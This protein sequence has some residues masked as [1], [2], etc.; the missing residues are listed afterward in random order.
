MSTPKGATP[1]PFARLCP[2]LIT[3]GGA[4]VFFFLTL[5]LSP[6]ITLANHDFA[7]D[8]HEVPKA[9][10]WQPG[11]K[12]LVIGGIHGDEPGGY[13]AAD[14]ALEGV[15]GKG[16]IH[17]IPRMN[18]RAII[19]NRRGVYAD[20]NRLFEHDISPR[21]PEQRT[22]RELISIIPQYD[23]ILSLHDG[24]GFYH[25]EYIDNVRNPRR[26]G[27]SIIIDTDIYHET[28]HGTVCLQCIAEEIIQTLNG[29]ILHEDHQF[30]VN[31]HNTASPQTIH[32]EQRTSL[33]F[34]TLTQLGV[35][36]FC[37]EASKLL[38]DI[39]QK[40]FYHINAIEGFAA[41]V[42]IEYHRPWNTY[43]DIGIF[44]AHTDHLHSVTI[45]INGA[46]RT[47]PP[48]GRIH[49]RP[50]DSIAV[51]EI[52]ASSPIGWYPDIYGTGFYDDSLRSFSVAEETK[53]VIRR[54]NEDRG[55]I[56][57]RL[58]DEPTEFFEALVDGE[59]HLLRQ[60]QVVH[61]HER[62]KILRGFTDRGEE[63]MVN[64]AGYVP[65]GLEGKIPD[66]RGYAL[67]PEELDWR[68]SVDRRGLQ[69]RVHSFADRTFRSTGEIYF[70]VD[71]MYGK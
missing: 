66:D 58:A 1:S 6:P 8:I 19:L 12:V 35:P 51:Q 18:K 50:G 55:I 42:G 68:Y 29:Q 43:A 15:V 10:K 60:G 33:T 49:V 16:E 41:A 65:P 53:I 26:Y 7:F 47:M 30:R 52:N 38:P 25:P 23:Y 45:A 20:M 64:V 40:V 69:Y 21:I 59:I 11:P 54:N 67:H 37:M 44:L 34:F 57:V 4:C 3:R 32:A 17:V 2:P 63:T 5:L 39:N 24:G 46:A 14:Y 71:D 27:Q 61:V 56:E 62:F 13:L 48:S 70:T 9:S 22:V 31:N 28:R 36:A